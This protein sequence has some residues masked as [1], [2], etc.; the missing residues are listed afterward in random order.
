MRLAQKARTYYSRLS[1]NKL[2]FM[3][4][5]WPNEKVSVAR[6]GERRAFLPSC[7]PGRRADTR[8]HVHYIRK[9]WFK[10]IKSPELAFIISSCLS[11]LKEF[12]A[13]PRPF[14]CAAVWSKH[15][16]LHFTA[17]S[18]S[19]SK[20]IWNMS[21]A[22]RFSSLREPDEFPNWNPGTVHI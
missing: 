21:C 1:S 6:V 17:L 14:M 20:R 19:S 15:D 11:L 18:S 5:H 7:S 22:G 2:P 13:T 3:T 12:P 10:P 8:Y 16:H 9:S 4:V